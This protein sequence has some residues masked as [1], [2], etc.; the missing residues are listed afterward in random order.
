MIIVSQNSIQQMTYNESS[1]VVNLESLPA[2][3]TSKIHF[4]CVYVENFVLLV[5]GHFFT[6]SLVRSYAIDVYSL[7]K[8]VWKKALYH[9]PVPISHSF[10]IMNEEKIWL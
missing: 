4:C 9:L 5:G 2:H 6:N 8:K 1:N 7:K 3:E 10:A